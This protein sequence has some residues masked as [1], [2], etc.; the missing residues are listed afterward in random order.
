MPYTTD[1]SFFVQ[2][3]GVP[4]MIFGPGKPELAHAVNEYVDMEM[5]KVATEVYTALMLRI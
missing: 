1:A 2:H 4:L 5:V 3:M